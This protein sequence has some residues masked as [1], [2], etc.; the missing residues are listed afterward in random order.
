MWSYGIRGIAHNWVKSYLSNRKQYVQLTHY[1]SQIQDFTA[2]VPQGSIIGPKLIIFF[3]NDLCNSTENFSYVLFADDT[4]VYCSEDNFNTEVSKK[5]L[6]RLSMDSTNI[7]MVE[8]TK[9]HGVTINSLG[10]L[11]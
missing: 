7:E 4:T 8:E 2:G 9:F 5:V 11:T 3:I 6:V 1:K 10:N